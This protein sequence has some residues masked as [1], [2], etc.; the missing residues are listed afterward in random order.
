MI[1]GDLLHVR[2]TASTSVESVFIT[3]WRLDSR[4]VARNATFS[5]GKELMRG[6]DHWVD[7]FEGARSRGPE[8]RFQL[9]E[10][11][12][13]RIELG[14]VGWKK[15]EMAPTCSI[16]ARTSAVCGQPGSKDDRVIC[17]RV[18]TTTCST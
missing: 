16:A 17:R 8:K 7:T 14:T 18:G 13:D 15:A 11:E 6:C 3:L 2:E 10:C 12:F 4:S 5:R 9:G 1:L